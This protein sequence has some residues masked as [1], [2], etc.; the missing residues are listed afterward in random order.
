MDVGSNIYDARR[1]NVGGLTFG[2]GNLRIPTDTIYGNARV[3]LNRN[4]ITSDGLHVR[5]QEMGAAADLSATAMNLETMRVDV[6]GEA[7]YQ[8]SKARLQAS[9]DIDDEAYD[10]TVHIDR[11]N[12]SPFNEALSSLS[13]NGD[14]TANGK[15]INPSKPL[16]TQV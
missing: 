1:L 12:L 10:A 16:Q 4:L 15:G 3:D 8:G 7:E 14:I 11:L 6:A 13:L 2:L 5:S 9:Y